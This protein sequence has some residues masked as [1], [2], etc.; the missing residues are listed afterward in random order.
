L[1]LDA[2]SR[3]SNEMARNWRGLCPVDYSDDD[4]DDDDK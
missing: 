3:G 2:S 1:E 4:D